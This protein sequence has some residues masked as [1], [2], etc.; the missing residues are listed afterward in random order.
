MEIPVYLFTGFLEAGKTK[1]IQETLEDPRFTDG[2]STLL[3][4]CE[5]GE[6]EY[7]EKRFPADG[8]HVAFIEDEEDL[9]EDKIKFLCST[10]K[11]ERVMVEYNGMWKNTS[12][13]SAM[14][15][16]FVIYQE[17][18]FVDSTTFLMYNQNM[19]AQVVD[20]F[21]TAELIV[22][23]RFM[24]KYGKMEFHKIVRGL[25]R[26]ANIIYEYM[27]GEAVQDDIEDPLPFDKEA[28]AFVV[29]DA[30]YALWYR[31]FG[32]NMMD[33]QG[34]TVTFKGIFLRD[35]SMPA[36]YLAAG[37]PIMTCCV[38]DI[39][40]S[41]FVCHFPGGVLPVEQSWGILKAKIDIRFSEVY[42]RE[43][44]VLECLASTPCEKPE[45]EV[46]T[47]Y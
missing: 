17:I 14:P 15:K 32:E 39:Q 47:F 21:S 25:S 46:A 34:K 2:T 30:D 28:D 9:T 22:F 43:G 5:E 20:K 44:P 4:V 33:Y 24:D 23:N 10:Y 12:F 38:D 37:R 8:V 3:I 29:Q 16:D 11:A 18:C 1:F 26:S 7:D 40:F 31:D 19:R 13:F 35:D 42:G 45:P 41:G 36:G 27:N 6:T